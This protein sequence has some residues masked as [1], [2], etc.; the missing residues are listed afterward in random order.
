MLDRRVAL[1]VEAARDADVDEL[2]REEPEL[3]GQIPETLPLLPD[4][5]ED[6]QRRDDAVAGGVA[7]EA[8]DVA[9]VLAAELPYFRY[10]FLQNVLV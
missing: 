8:D 9:G 7:V 5:G 3:A 10:C 1:P 4:R 6:L 2:L